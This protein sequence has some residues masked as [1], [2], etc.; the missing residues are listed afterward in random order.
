[1]CMCEYLGKIRY[2]Y[3]D[4]VVPRLLRCSRVHPSSP[5]W[6]RR[7]L[8]HL[9]QSRVFSFSFSFWL[10]MTEILFTGP[11]NLTSNKQTRVT[12]RILTYC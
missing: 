12:K 8:S 2:M 10:D 1:M 5:T 7:F 6:V 3:C 9:K 4:R 11:L